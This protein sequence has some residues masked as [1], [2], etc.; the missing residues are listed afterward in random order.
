MVIPDVEIHLSIATCG[1]VIQ[2]G[3]YHALCPTCALKVDMQKDSTLLH[4][5]HKSIESILAM[6]LTN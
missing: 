2:N 4:E 5:Q 6:L 1:L 3:L